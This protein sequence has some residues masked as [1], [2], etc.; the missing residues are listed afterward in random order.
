MPNCKAIG[1]MSRELLVELGKRPGRD[2]LRKS[3]IRTRIFELKKHEYEMVI[4]NFNTN[5]L[6]NYR[7]RY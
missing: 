2:E 5:N 1:G 6:Y 7:S 4:N 3:K